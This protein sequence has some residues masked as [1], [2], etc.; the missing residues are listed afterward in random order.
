MEKKDDI[1]TKWIV[2]VTYVELLLL[3]QAVANYE[4]SEIFFTKQEKEQTL[5]AIN[6]AK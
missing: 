6:N 1:W 4:P 5:K 2:E 3:K